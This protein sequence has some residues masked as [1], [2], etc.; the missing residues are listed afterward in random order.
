MLYNDSIWV[1]LEFWSN[2]GLTTWWIKSVQNQD[3][4]W[5]CEGL[6]PL[7]SKLIEG[8]FTEYVFRGNN[9]VSHH[10]CQWI[11]SAPLPVFYWK[12][13]CLNINMIVI[14]VAFIQ[15]INCIKW[16]TYFLKNVSKIEWNVSEFYPQI[17]KHSFWYCRSFLL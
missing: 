10:Q 9:S 11:M 7:G 3:F 1:I 4:C 8:N 5:L 15:F 6:Y 13:S 14:F 16:C 12:Y 2:L 17:R